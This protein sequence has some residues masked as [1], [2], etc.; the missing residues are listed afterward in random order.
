MSLHSDP[1]VAN[2]NSKI[3]NNLPVTQLKQKLEQSALLL[4]NVF[5]QV[6]KKE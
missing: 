3:I 5:A 2:Y 6:Y 4:Q 1:M